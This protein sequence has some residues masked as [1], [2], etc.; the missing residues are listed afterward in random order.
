[1]SVMN[2]DEMIVAINEL[3]DERGPKKK[4]SRESTSHKFSRYVN[5]LRSGNLAEI[6]KALPQ[7]EKFRQEVYAAR[8]SHVSLDSALHNA[9]RSAYRKHWGLYMD[10]VRLPSNN[11]EGL[12]GVRTN[13]SFKQGVVWVVS[14]NGQPSERLVLLAPAYGYRWIDWRD[15]PRPFVRFDSVR[16]IL[17]Y[18]GFDGRGSNTL[19][20][21]VMPKV[22]I[23]GQP[24][25]LC[26]RGGDG[27]FLTRQDPPSTK[28]GG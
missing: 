23:D 11:R 2:P 25:S 27:Y 15:T 3:Y 26:L 16:E 21:L 19:E 24:D 4:W 14:S 7:I 8:R 18:N 20:Y 12:G 9:E 22:K 1:M 13:D 17:S 5:L 10:L 6:R 28:I